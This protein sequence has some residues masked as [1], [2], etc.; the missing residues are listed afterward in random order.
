MKRKIC[1]F[2]CLCSLFFAACSKKGTVSFCEGVDADGKGV[3]CGSVFTTGDLTAVFDAKNSFATDT[4]EIKI[5]NTKDGSRKPFL[6]STAAVN[7][8]DSKG[9]ADLELYDEGTFRV[10]VQK[11]DGET[12]SEGQIEIID[13]YT[14]PQ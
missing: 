2:I 11:H 14:K 10:V 8:D 12:V 5:Y 6:S 1:F 4:L 3:N 7:P 13:S 9:K